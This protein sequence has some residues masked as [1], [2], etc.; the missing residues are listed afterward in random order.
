MFGLL[1]EDWQNACKSIF[2]ITKAKLKNSFQLY[3]FSLLSSNEQ[4]L[5]QS[6]TFFTKYIDT[7]LYMM[8]L[9]SIFK[10]E[11][12][13]SK[14]DLNFRNMSLISPI[15]YLVL[16]AI[17]FMLFRNN[18]DHRNVDYIST[19]YSGD[20]SA[21][22]SYY[23]KPYDDFYKEVNYLKG[24]YNYFIKLD[25]SNFFPSVNLNV[26]IDKIQKN[27]SS[28]DS[29]DLQM[30]KDYLSYLGNGI[31]PT[32]ENSTALSYIATIIYLE[33]FDN[34][35]IS[36][37]KQIEEITSF[38]C[39]RYVDDLYILLNKSN[40]SSIKC[41][42]NKFIFIVTNILQKSCLMYNQNKFSIREIDQINEVLSQSF[43]NRDVKDIDYNILDLF[44]DNLLR[45]FLIKLNDSSLG[46]DLLSV[47]DYHKLVDKTFRIEDIEYSSKEVF[48]NFC[49]CPQLYLTTYKRILKCLIWKNYEIIKYDIKNFLNLILNLKDGD[50]IKFLLNKIYVQI[51]E[52][53]YDKYDTLIIINYLIKRNMKNEDFLNILKDQEKPIYNFI[54]YFCKSSFVSLLVKNK[55]INRFYNKYL[56]KSDD[57]LLY[58]YSMYIFTRSRGDMIYAFG[59]FSSFL[60]RITAHIA[61]VKER[62]E[63]ERKPNY[64]KYYTEDHLKSFWNNDSLIEEYKKIRNNSPII[65]NNCAKIIK[66][67]N[68][69]I[70]VIIDKLYDEIIKEINKP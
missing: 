57:I 44:D 11:Y 40:D 50:L 36:E 46:K 47:Y 29:I 63:R 22:T 14:E 39:V 70:L 6:N 26:L 65:H 20:L 18:T 61:F 38:R 12:K 15:D 28:I 54:E 32:V 41:V 37:L 16:T 8:S 42:E 33:D 60:E 1:Y 30:I 53:E 34:Q 68:K 59:F 58:L 5:L 3:P 45:D 62:Q 52:K 35:L 17:A 66:M 19:Y 9:K 51:R 48:R 67:E 7:S 27:C 10:T 25:I 55:T 23:A 4:E 13:I 64:K 56:Y 24:E 31:F 69:E 21:Q 43:Y 49:F 2:K